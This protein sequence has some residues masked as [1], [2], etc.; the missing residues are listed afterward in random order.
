[1]SF[2]DTYRRRV[3]DIADAEWRKGR[4][5]RPTVYWA[6]VLRQRETDPHPKHWCGAFALYCL[7]QAG[8]GLELR[9]RF[10]SEH[11]PRSGFLWA[12]PRVHVPEPGDIAYFDH[13]QHHAIVRCVVGETDFDSIDGNQGPL[14]PIKLHERNLGEAAFFSIA[15]LIVPAVDEPEGS[16]RA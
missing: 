3:I 6:D 15:A 1:L 13:W 7:H 16:A 11:D 12:L 14:T 4:D 8:L 2:A 10:S 5:V 9:W